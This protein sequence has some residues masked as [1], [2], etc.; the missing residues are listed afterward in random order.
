[1][2]PRLVDYL[3]YEPD[4]Q[5]LRG[6]PRFAKVLTASRD[7][8]AKIARILEQARARGELPKYLETPLDDLLRLLN[9]KGKES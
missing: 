5:P 3:L 9:E 7:G 2:G 1:M 4:F 8:A 6:D